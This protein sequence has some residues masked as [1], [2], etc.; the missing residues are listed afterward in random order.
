MQNHWRLLLCCTMLYC[1][2]AAPAQT[3]IAKVR[4]AYSGFWYFNYQYNN[5]VK[6]IPASLVLSR[7]DTDGSFIRPNRTG[8]QADLTDTLFKLLYV[9]EKPDS[10]G[11]YQDA[12]VK[13]KLYKAIYYWLNH[14]PAFA[15]TGS[16]MAQPTSL[17]MI[18]TKLYDNFQADAANPA[19]AAMI[20]NIRQRAMGF[21]RY[22]WSKG[23]TTNSFTNPN[24]GDNPSEAYDWQRLGNVGYR[25]FGYTGIISAC[26]DSTAMDTLSIILSNQFPLQVNKPGQTAI[27]A[28][29]YDGSVF[30]HSAPSPSYQGSQFYNGNYGSDWLRDLGRYCNWVKGTKWALTT[31]QQQAWGDILLNGM[32]WIQYK[33]RTA[34][35]I[36]GRY[37]GKAGPAGTQLTAM[38][39]EYTSVAD[40]SLPQRA[41]L[42]ALQNNLSNA[43]YQLDSSKYFWNAHIILHH[44]PNY[45]AS[46]RMLST[47]A[48][49]AESSDASQ[50]TGKTNFYVSDGSVMLYRK[51]TEYDNARA[52]WNWRCIPGATIKQRTGTLD[53]VPWSSGYESNN[54]IA[55]GVS[56]GK[57]SM[58]VFNL[59]RTH[60][61][62][63]TK[64]FKA[65][66]A[67][68]DALICAGNAISDAGTDAGDVYTTLNQTERLTD[69]Y[70]SVNGGAE[71]TVSPASTLDTSFDI[72]SPSWFWQDSVGYIILPR[73]GVATN[74]ILSAETRSGNWH[75]LDNTNTNASVSVN[76][77]QLSINHGSTGNLKDTTYRYVIV[78]SVSKAGLVNFFNNK[79]LAAGA[80]AVYI[81]YNSRTIAA[82]YN[83]YTGVFFTNAGFSKATN[84]GTDSLSISAS[85]YAAVLVK[86]ETNGM[87]MHV[88]DLR[89]GFYT[90]TPVDLGFNKIFKS[91]SFTPARAYGPVTI[92][93]AA[94][95]TLV[96]L[97]LSKTSAVYTGE[98][99]DFFAENAAQPGTRSANAVAAA[100]TAAAAT[101][102]NQ[103]QLD[104]S[105][106]A[107]GSYLVQLVTGNEAKT[108]KLLKEK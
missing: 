80:G 101:G 60:S 11:Y 71:Q 79:V 33:G 21:V 51:G 7:I 4:N 14:Y 13:D 83:G 100:S 81:H 20:S 47:R 92:T 82:S 19:Y 77:F 48:V 23:A 57:V 44:S 50:G 59:S 76:I 91:D 97:N 74:A 64:A 40:S 54:V 43:A 16:A 38:L 46:I 72:S 73:A 1:S 10:A 22:S 105:R 12:A 106:Y 29:A 88:S 87:H 35:N 61:K 28:A 24:L 107:N 36:I 75:D 26:D 56:D 2:T 89:N 53:L 67:F 58:G 68:T 94:D 95:S 98:P 49:G 104:I 31:A 108:V 55:G 17:G 27:V 93:P 34:H 5:A 37:T 70:Y 66:F 25:V 3:D 15:W 86:R 6:P 52:G 32:E 103:R 63:T 39:S 65:Y 62:A 85:N 45:F 9:F 42:L 41:Q 18:M 96:S 99:V 90:S 69:I 84:L 78:P 102:V 8:T 30:Q